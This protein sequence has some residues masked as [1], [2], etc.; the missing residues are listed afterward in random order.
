MLACVR[1][2]V[3]ACVRAC[4]LLQQADGS[5]LRSYF[6]MEARATQA[7]PAG[8]GRAHSKYR[9]QI[10]GSSLTEEA[11]LTLMCWQKW[12]YLLCALPSSGSCCRWL[13]IP[14]QPVSA[15]AAL[16]APPCQCPG[17]HALPW[18]IM[19]GTP[20][21]ITRAPAGC[22]PAP[23]AFSSCAGRDGGVE[24]DDEGDPSKPSEPALDAE[25]DSFLKDCCCVSCASE[26][27]ASACARS[28]G[29]YMGC[30]PLE[31]S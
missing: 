12:Q 10:K 2:C 1:A 13:A 24:G 9:Q 19:F 28:P 26:R 15:A 16:L 25:R 30:R 11:R 4:G 7:S 14:T 23:M 17:P 8:Q 3:C 6:R 31:G 29:V 27:L 21:T 18:I 22:P 20:S 5:E